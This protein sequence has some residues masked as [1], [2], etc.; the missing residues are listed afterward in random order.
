LEPDRTPKLELIAESCNPTDNIRPR[1]RIIHG[2]DE[3]GTPIT[4]LFVGLDSQTNGSAVLTSTFSA[5]YALLGI[6][7]ADSDS[8]VAH[9]LRFRVQ[10]LYG[11]GAIRFRSDRG[12]N[13]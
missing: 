9:S 5:G 13:Q 12:A 1:G 2:K 7:L 4:L 10:H 6:D 8:F 11:F 3:R